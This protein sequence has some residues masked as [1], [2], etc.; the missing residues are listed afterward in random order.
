MEACLAWFNQQVQNQTLHPVLLAAE[1]HE[2][3]VSIHP[4]IDGNGRTSRLVMNLLLMQYGYPIANISGDRENRFRYYDVLELCH[5]GDKSQFL[6]FIAQEVKNSME[7]LIK[8]AKG[9]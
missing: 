4:F 5:N 3:V 9:E 2:R 1:M 6:L 8:I 7:H